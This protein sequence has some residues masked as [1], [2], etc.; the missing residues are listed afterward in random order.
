MKSINNVQISIFITSVDIFISN[1]FDLV[2][3]M[4]IISIS[5]LTNRD[6]D[7]IRLLNDLGLAY[8]DLALCF[9][10]SENPIFVLVVVDLQFDA[11]L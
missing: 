1:T 6:N 9:G 3:T 5:H 11:P 7:F 10:D 2:E 8:S 4:P